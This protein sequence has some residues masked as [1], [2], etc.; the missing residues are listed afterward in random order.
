MPNSDRLIESIPVLHTMRVLLDEFG[1]YTQVARSNPFVMRLQPPL[2][3]T[4]EQIDEVVDAIGQVAGQL[5][6]SNRLIEGMITKTVTGQ[7]DGAQR[8]RQET[9]PAG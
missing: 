2:I 8:T 4:D 6:A 5:D 7:H 3:V 9:L 1:V